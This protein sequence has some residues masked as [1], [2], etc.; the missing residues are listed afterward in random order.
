MTLATG[1]R[2]GPYEILTPLGAGGMGE[3]YRARDTRL[4]RE[5]A[6]KVLPEQLAFNPEAL[7]RFERE[8]RAVASLS[9]PNILALHDFGNAGNVSYAVMELLEGETLAQ[10]LSD[11]A[12]PLRKAT[13]WALQIAH[14]LAAAHGRG[15]VHRDLK[16]E[17]VFVTSDGRVKILDFGLARPAGGPALPDETRSPTVTAH[18]EPGAVMGTV[19]Y[20]SPEQVR[21]LPVDVRSDIFSFGVVLYEMLSGKRAFQ[22]DTAAETMTAILKEEPPEFSDSGRSVP[23][24]LDRLVRHCLEVRVVRIEDATVLPFAIRFGMTTSRLAGVTAR[25]RWMPDGRAIAFV[26]V[27]A[28]GRTGIYVQDFVPGK[29]TQASRR[30]LAGF[31]ADWATETFGIS[32]DGSRILWGSSKFGGPRDLPR[33]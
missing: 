2:L 27:D 16:P 30:P 1:S 11:G 13:E 12:L 3:V 31:N 24:V 28:R 6:V 15:I 14:G 4:G 19:G 21:G 7:S 20:M 8:A 26:D 17:N 33:N 23:P 22:R 32:P 25:A 29:E 5:V 10:V 18:T 9:H